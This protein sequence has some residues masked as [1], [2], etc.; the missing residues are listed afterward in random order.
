MGNKVGK[1]GRCPGKGYVCLTAYGGFIRRAVSAKLHTLF[2]TQ[3][4]STYP[5][6]VQNSPQIAP[7]F[8]SHSR[9]EVGLS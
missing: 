8:L 2:T 6:A 7:N 5:H 9:P 3:N 1:N 4:W